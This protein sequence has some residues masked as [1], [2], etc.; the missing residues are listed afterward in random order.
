[1]KSNI[2]GIISNVIGTGFNILSIDD[3]T[4]WIPTS[5]TI[6]ATISADIYS[7]LPC[8]KGCSLSGGILANL[9]PTIVITD[10]AI[11]DKLL[12]ASAIIAI[13]DVNKP[14]DNFTP[15]NIKFAIIP[16]IPAR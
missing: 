2:N 14:T 1:M 16:T 6:N 15:N 13:L 8:P 12:N 5:I 4:N 7:S 9:N 3:F 10:D 11:S